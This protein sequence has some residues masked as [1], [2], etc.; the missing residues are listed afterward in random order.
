[1][2]EITNAI[3]SKLWK[4][5]MYF[6]I[7]T[8]LEFCKRLFLTPSLCCKIY[9]SFQCSTIHSSSSQWVGTSHGFHEGWKLKHSV[10]EMWSKCIS[11]KQCQMSSHLCVFLEETRRRT[12]SVTPSQLLVSRKPYYSVGFSYLM[13][14]NAQKSNVHVNNVNIQK[15]IHVFWIMDK[16]PRKFARLW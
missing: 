3:S 14:D 6:S 13:F 15:V 5:K 10:S 12:A 2:V 9:W 11:A 7:K 4:F 16:H 8:K 1:M